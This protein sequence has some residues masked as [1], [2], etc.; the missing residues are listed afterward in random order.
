MNFEATVYSENV[1][2]GMYSWGC[3]SSE[4]HTALKDNIVICV[5]IARNADGE[6]AR[7]AI[8]LSLN[9]R[10]NHAA[11]GE[12]TAHASNKVN[13]DLRLLRDMKGRNSVNFLLFGVPT[14]RVDASRA[15][16]DSFRD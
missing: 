16:L 10:R 14:S 11:E 12:D 1:Q 7:P 8:R 3:S 15:C 2:L 6:R 5:S 13:I 9:F 4:T